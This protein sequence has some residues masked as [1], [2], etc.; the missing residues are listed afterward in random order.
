[1]VVEMDEFLAAMCPLMDDAER[2][3]LLSHLAYRPMAG[4]IVIG[5]GGVRKLRWGLKS[6]ATGVEPA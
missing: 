4:L 3:D 2:A 1:M 6:A 5:P